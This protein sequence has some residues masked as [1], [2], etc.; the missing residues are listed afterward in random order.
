MQAQQATRLNQNDLQAFLQESLVSQNQDHRVGFNVRCLNLDPLRL[1][2]LIAGLLLNNDLDYGEWAAAK[3][4][5]FAQANDLP[6][7][8]LIQVHY[9]D[10]ESKQLLRIDDFTSDGQAAHPLEYLSL[11]ESFLTLAVSL[12]LF[13]AMVAGMSFGVVRYLTRPAPQS[14]PAPMVPTQPNSLEHK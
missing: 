9:F 10:F 5:E 11:P 2:V 4:Y 3:L 13:A 14:F 7:V 6:E 12:S 1:K 8:E